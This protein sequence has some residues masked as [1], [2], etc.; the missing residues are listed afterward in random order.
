LFLWGL[1]S[2]KSIIALDVGFSIPWSQVK[3]S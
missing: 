3:P 1:N 2:F